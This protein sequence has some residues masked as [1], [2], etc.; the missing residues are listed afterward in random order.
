MIRVRLP[1]IDYLN[2]RTVFHVVGEY[3]ELYWL[4]NSEVPN[5]HPFS[6]RKEKCEIIEEAA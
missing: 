4:V 3:G 5:H 6:F 2:L 1:R